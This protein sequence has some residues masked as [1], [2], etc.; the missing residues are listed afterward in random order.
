MID[1]K[2]AYLLSKFFL[3]L[4]KT[5]YITTFITPPLVGTA[6]GI[7]LLTKGV[8]SIIIFLYL[9]REML[10]FTDSYGF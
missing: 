10:K 7:Y 3:D 8:A 6:M 1:S 2:L 9:A 5:Y 4:A